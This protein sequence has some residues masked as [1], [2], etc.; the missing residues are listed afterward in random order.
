M[1]ALYYDFSY[2]VSKG[3][4]HIHIKEER[5]IFE[6]AK[7]VY[8]FMMALISYPIYSHDFSLISSNITLYKDIQHDRIVKKLNQGDFS[9]YDR[10]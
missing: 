2:L 4:F 1:T 8:V 6:E 5:F 7:E 9:N 10:L 3:I